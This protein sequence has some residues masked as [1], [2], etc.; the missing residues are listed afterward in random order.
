MTE[1]RVTWPP[2]TTLVIE[3]EP[4]VT[5]TASLRVVPPV[6]PGALL[7]VECLVAREFQ[8]VDVTA[9]RPGRTFTRPAGFEFD[10]FEQWDGGKWVVVYRAKPVA[11]INQ[12]VI[13]TRGVYLA[14]WPAEPM[15][16]DI[17]SL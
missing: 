7:R 4:P 17:G 12:L 10:I 11:G 3:S 9:G 15:S 14:D 6:T 8:W 1:I 13:V 5:Y 2:G 16:A